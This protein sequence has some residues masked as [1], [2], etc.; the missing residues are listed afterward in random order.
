MPNRQNHQPKFRQLEHRHHMD[1]R[2]NS[3]RRLRC[4][5]R[6]WTY[7]NLTKWLPRRNQE[8]GFER[9]IEAGCWGRGEGWFLVFCLNLDSS[10]FRIFR[11]FVEHNP[12]NPLIQRIQIQTKLTTS[13]PPPQAILSLPYI[14]T[15]HLR[16]LIRRTHGRRSP[17]CSP[18]RQNLLRQLMRMH[19]FLP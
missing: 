8:I 14:P 13:K 15:K 1:V 18:Q 7:R 10:D 19:R 11:I 12:I 9:R 16:P 6:K 17:H 5:H 2:T 4:H 3:N